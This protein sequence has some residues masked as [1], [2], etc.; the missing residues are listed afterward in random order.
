MFYFEELTNMRHMI[1]NTMVA[2]ISSKILQ[3]RKENIKQSLSDLNTI[4]HRQDYVA[5]IDGVMYYDDSRAENVNATWFTFE[6]IV[7][8]VIWIAGG[9]DRDTDF[10]DLKQV[11]K[12][13]VKALI[14]IG[15]YNANL[16]KSFQKDIK[17]IY[18]VTDIEEAIDTASFLAKQDDVVLFSPACKSDKE[19]ETFVERG[20]LF[21]ETVKKLE[22][23]YHQ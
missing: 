5:T 19:D 10:K 11:A 13:K 23:E 17:D 1:H 14:C 2:G 12:K 3:I 18:E 8:P 20:N 15:K 9:N 16:K 22:N 4:E 6:N 21:T 7:K